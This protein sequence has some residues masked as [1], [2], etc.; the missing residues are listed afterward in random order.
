MNDKSIY[1]SMGTMQY[2]LS[3]Q[4]QSFDKRFHETEDMVQFVLYHKERVGGL[5]TDHT[6]LGWG[7]GL[8][9]EAGL[10]GPERWANWGFL[11]EDK[12]LLA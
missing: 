5:L 3:I 11:K 8:R 7:E 2:S 10:I 4:N 1:Y 6:V 9:P 12:K